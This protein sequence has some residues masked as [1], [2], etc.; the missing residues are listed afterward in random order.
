MG[1]K[2]SC[3]E[4]LNLSKVSDASR[5]VHLVLL[6][7]HHFG[8]TMKLLI[9]R[10]RNKQ[11]YVPLHRYVEDCI[12]YLKFKVPCT[13]KCKQ[14][15]K[16][17]SIL[18]WRNQNGNLLKC[19][20]VPICV[21]NSTSISFEAFQINDAGKSTSCFIRSFKSKIMPCKLKVNVFYFST[22]ILY[23]CFIL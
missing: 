9:S 11:G 5:V 19:L 20:S 16:Q 2:G 7:F 14:G 21:S 8:S 15:Y 13:V 1:R 17:K 12:L 4:L 3:Y 18:L 23:P 6:H 10:Q 22:M